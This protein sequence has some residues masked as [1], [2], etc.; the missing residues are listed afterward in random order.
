MK[1]LELQ[2][3]NHLY[4]QGIVE[5]GSEPDPIYNFLRFYF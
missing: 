1:E 3:V 5:L 2:K 4:A